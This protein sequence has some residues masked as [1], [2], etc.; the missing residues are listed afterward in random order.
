M[1][2]EVKIEAKGYELKARPVVPSLPQGDLVLTHKRKSPDF[3]AYA[4][5]ELYLIKLDL[6][7]NAR[8]D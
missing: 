7:K 3:S 6:S 8:N 2:Y 4:A 1:F 5:N